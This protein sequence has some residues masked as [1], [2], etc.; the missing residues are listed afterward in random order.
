MSAVASIM[1]AP[2]LKGRKP[3]AS[4][5]ASQPQPRAAAAAACPGIETHYTPAQMM[6]LR[7]TDTTRVVPDSVR[8]LASTLWPGGSVV[9][10]ALC[11]S[12][13]SVCRQQQKLLQ[14]PLQQCTDDE[15][16]NIAK[17]IYQEAARPLGC[18]AEY[19]SLIASLKS[20][21]GWQHFGKTLCEVIVDACQRQFD[22]RLA[23][24]G[25]PRTDEEVAATKL[26][27]PL[28]ANIKFLGHLFLQGIVEEA[29]VVAALS[30]LLCVNDERKVQKLFQ[31][32]LAMF[33]DLL[34]IVFKRLTPTALT[35]FIPEGVLCFD[36]VN[37]SALSI[38]RL[39]HRRIVD[40]CNNE[41][42]G[43]LR[44]KTMPSR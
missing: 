15:I 25:T 9:D 27:P 20:H 24:A 22:L 19:A 28:R 7:S 21:T 43:K 30:V 39:L 4:Q 8:A 1:S 29:V 40:L 23:E 10:Y 3:H 12:H 11:S 38:N 37:T 34:G 35:E 44:F 42:V 41:S 36:D 31:Y 14:L 32:E 5:A 16:A 18:H 33:C 26:S 2:V 17:A 13:D 6:T